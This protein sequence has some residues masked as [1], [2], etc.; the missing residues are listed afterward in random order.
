MNR[1]Q[2]QHAE[3]E[4]TDKCTGRIRNVPQAEFVPHAI[5]RQLEKLSFFAST[6]LEALT[7]MSLAVD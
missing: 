6:E 1:R 2:L 3:E 5:A 4:E 7:K